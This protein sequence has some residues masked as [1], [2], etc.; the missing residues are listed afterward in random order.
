M[1]IVL[2]PHMARLNGRET[3]LAGCTKHECTA[4]DLCLRADDRLALRIMP[5]AHLRTGTDCPYF[6]PND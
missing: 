1:N 2:S 5:K 6:I 4:R 3:G